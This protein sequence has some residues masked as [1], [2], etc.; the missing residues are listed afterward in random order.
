MRGTDDPL[1]VGRLAL[2]GDISLSRQTDDQPW[3]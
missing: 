2:A 3:L 1:H